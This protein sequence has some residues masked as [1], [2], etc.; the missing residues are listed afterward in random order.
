MNISSGNNTITLS[1][2]I[3]FVVDEECGLKGY[4]NSSKKP[5]ILIMWNTQDAVK[6]LVSV[7]QNHPKLYTALPKRFRSDPSIKSVALIASMDDSQSESNRGKG[8]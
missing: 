2:G 4:L 7:V 6:K 8:G 1:R 5:D 3:L